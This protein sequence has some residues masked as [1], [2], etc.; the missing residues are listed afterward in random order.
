MTC[1][2]KIISNDYADLLVDFAVTEEMAGTTPLDFCFHAIDGIYGVANFLR[3]QIP[4]V[5]VGTYGYSAIPKL[6]GLMQIE[7]ARFQPE[8][9]VST[10]NL[11]VQGAPLSLQGEGVLIGLVDTGGGVI[12]L[13]I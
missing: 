11:R 6:Y 2:E 3:S 8:N 1:K 9:L 13:F 5:S 7:Q 10:G 12:I 4:P